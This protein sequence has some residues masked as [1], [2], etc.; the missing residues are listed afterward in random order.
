MMLEKAYCKLIG[1]DIAAILRDNG[2]REHTC[3]CA[4]DLVN[5]EGYICEKC[6]DTGRQWMPPKAEDDFLMTL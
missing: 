1:V 2:W 4:W 5:V 3:Y 6:G